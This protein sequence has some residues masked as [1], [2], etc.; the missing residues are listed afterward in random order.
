MHTESQRETWN[1]KKISK[2][3]EEKRKTEL[4]G[5][6]DKNMERHGVKNSET[7]R[8]RVREKE[9]KRKRVNQ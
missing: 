4:H 6:K 7:E 5:G 3:M 9:T 1:K 2:I 8:K